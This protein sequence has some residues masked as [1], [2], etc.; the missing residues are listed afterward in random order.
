MTSRPLHQC[1]PDFKSH[2]FK[3]AAQLMI[4]KTQYLDSLFREE[5]VSFFIFGTLAWKTVPT[6]IQ[7][8]RELCDGAKEIEEINTAGILATE[9][10]LGKTPIA[11]QT[12]QALF[13]F[14]GIVPQ[15]A[16]KVA[17][18]GGARAVFA[19]LRRLPPHPGPLP[20]WGRGRTHR[21][22]AAI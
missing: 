11:Q 20:R 19:V 2:R 21:R 3:F 10:E 17:G 4:P 14:S 9:F 1:V 5:L 7:L 8:N 15:L 6:A 12:P 16:S 13:S 22:A 18:R